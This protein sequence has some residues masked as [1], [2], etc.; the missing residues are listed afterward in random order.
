MKDFT[1]QRTRCG[2]LTRLLSGFV[3]TRESLLNTILRTPVDAELNRTYSR[4]VPAPASNMSAALTR[5]FTQFAE[6]AV[7][8]DG[9]SVDYSRL[10]SSNV[11]TTY[12]HT[13]TQQLRIFNPDSLHTREQQ[14]AFWINLYNALII[15]AVIAFDVQT[16]VTEG[17]L[18]VARFLRRAAYEIGGHRFSANDIEHGILRSNRGFPSFLGPQFAAMD[19]RHA[20]AITPFDARIHTALNC[21]SRS[22]PPLR[23]YDAKTI[24]KQLDC[25]AREF[26]VSD[27]ALD[28]ESNALHLSSIFKWFQDDFGG[29][30][31]IVDFIR[32]H[33][34]DEDER[35]T[36]LSERGADVELIY[37]P[38]DWS[39]NAK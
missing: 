9:Y 37:K 5:I 22:C 14:L 39:L 4:D 15:D 11:Y 30:K 2:V 21:A 38:Y 17:V 31:G 24:D 26:V 23:V 29:R 19:A 34:P 13:F 3:S 18:G 20:F 1:L 6:I 33:L 35:H 28:K 36:W 8:D 16:S 25:A 12:H 27:L 7:S 32:E 10:R